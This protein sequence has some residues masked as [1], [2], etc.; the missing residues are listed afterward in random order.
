ME[1]GHNCGD[2]MCRK[3]KWTLGLS[4][5][6]LKDSDLRFTRTIHFELFISLDHIV[7][8]KCEYKK[9]YRVALPGLFKVTKN[10]SLVM[11]VI[12]AELVS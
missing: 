11:K 1:T 7:A 2:V 6:I 5:V 10:G 8:T 3:L 4:N 9:Y 12:K